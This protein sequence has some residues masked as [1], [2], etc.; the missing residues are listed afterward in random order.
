MT[1]NKIFKSKQVPG[2]K[3]KLQIDELSSLKP[4]SNVYPSKCNQVAI[5]I[6]NKE[7]KGS[8]LPPQK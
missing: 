5:S 3:L 8:T 1:V 6:K 7:R 2:E 4:G